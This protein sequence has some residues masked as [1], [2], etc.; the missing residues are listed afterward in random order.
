[1]LQGG[2]DYYHPEDRPR[3]QATVD[4]AIKKGQPY[5]FTARI[6]TETGQTKNVLSRGICRRDIHGLV[7]QVYGVFIETAH[8]IELAEFVNDNRQLSYPEDIG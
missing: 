8:V 2:I 1:M 3:V 7:S 6:V 4:R 5:E